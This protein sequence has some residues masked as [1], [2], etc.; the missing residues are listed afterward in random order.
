MIRG[1]RRRT[2]S[3]GAS[4]C[5]ASGQKNRQ[6]WGGVYP[7]V[8][9]SS[10]VQFCVD[11]VE[12]GECTSLQHF[13]R[14]GTASVPVLLVAVTSITGRWGGKKVGQLLRVPQTNSLE[15]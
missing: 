15:R 3:E 2:A 4:M 8:R 1:C 10:L 11:K 14:E 6:R 9:G 12:C 13:L 7:N 5:S